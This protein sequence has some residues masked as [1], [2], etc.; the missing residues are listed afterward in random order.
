MTSSKPVPG[1]SIRQSFNREITD[2]RAI[3][4]DHPN[5]SN[6][7]ARLAHTY[8]NLW[9]YGLESYREVIPDAEQ[10]VEKALAFDTNCG[11]AYTARGIIKQANRDWSGI[12]DELILGIQLAPDD[13]LGYNWYSNYLY[14]TN[15]FDESYA[16]AEK[17]VM[18]SDDPGYKIGLGAISYFTRDF[19]RLKKE[20][21]AV[22]SEHPDYAPAYD[23]LGMAYIQ[24]NEFDK[25]IAAYET[26]ATLSG[27]LAEILGGLGHAYGMAGNYREARQVLREMLSYQKDFHIPPVQVAF[28]YASLGDNDNV[29]KML[30]RAVDEKS[31]ELVFV[32][33]E[34]WFEH[35]QNDQWMIS[36]VRRMNFPSQY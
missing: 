33:T 6:T 25:S 4:M 21:Q 28:I 27:R 12:D 29:F 17:A 23:W 20:M 31:W 22:I 24:L 15:R 34:P 3:L 16:M 32:R 11:P 14:A 30:E 10:A 26:A 18:L 7:L 13:A 5:D 2:C 1:Q 8:I 36:I 35:L 9:C 19:R